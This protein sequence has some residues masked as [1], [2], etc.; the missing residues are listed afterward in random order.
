MAAKGKVDFKLQ[1]GFADNFAPGLLTGGAVL[2]FGVYLPVLWEM[3]VMEDMQQ[4]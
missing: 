4:S 1:I 2:R 3:P